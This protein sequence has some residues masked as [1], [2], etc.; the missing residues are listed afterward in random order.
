MEHCSRCA[1][2]T[3]RLV[4]AVLVVTRVHH[5]SRAW[6]ALSFTEDRQTATANATETKTSYGAPANIVVPPANR[7]TPI[8]KLGGQFGLS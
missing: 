8:A 2:S 1:K 3:R 4:P 5:H 7:V 6:V